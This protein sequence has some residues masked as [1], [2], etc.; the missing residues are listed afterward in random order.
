MM[1]MQ[2]DRNEHQPGGAI[3]VVAKCSIQGKTKTRLIPLLGQE[4][5][6]RF[7]Q[8]LLSDVL[9]SLSSCVSSTFCGQRIL[10]FVKTTLTKLQFQLDKVLKVLLYAPGNAE[11]VKLMMELLVSL[12]LHEHWVLLP[13]SSSTDLLSSGIGNI[14]TNALERVRTLLRNHHSS[15]GSV[16]FLGMD[17]PELPLEEVVTSLANTTKA[18]LCPA[19]DGGYGML[20][21]PPHAP[22]SIFENV[23]WSQSLTAVSQLKALTDCNVDVKLGRLMH[24]MDE[25]QDVQALVERLCQLKSLSKE[26]RVD[27]SND[28]V[29][30]KSSSGASM[31]PTTGTCD[32]TWN[33]I[34]SLGLIQQHNGKYEIRQEAFS[35]ILL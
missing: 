32:H 24:D 2:E 3:V 19:N 14:L 22:L 17:S 13:V 9:Q 16:V 12:N 30:L 11:G 5:S 7:A 35:S 27:E 23:R 33:T 26:G 25:A 31:A 4:G 15:N 34:Q 21:V 6:A 1:T 29:L 8:A 20:S 10:K 28:D 18:Y